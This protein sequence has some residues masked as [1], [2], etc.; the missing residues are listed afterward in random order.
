MTTTDVSYFNLYLTNLLN[1]QSDSR[2]SD[3]TFIKERADA[4]AAQFEQSRLEGKTVNEAM[5]IAMYVLV[6]GI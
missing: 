1:E 4:A 3:Q 6:S 5:E 2:R